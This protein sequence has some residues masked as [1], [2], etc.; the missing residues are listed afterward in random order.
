MFATTTTTSLGN[1]GFKIEGDSFEE[2]IR[3]IRVG[4]L[5]EILEGSIKVERVAIGACS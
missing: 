3:G 2:G 1:Q 4:I 5:V